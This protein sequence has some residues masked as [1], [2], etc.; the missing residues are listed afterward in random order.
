[1]PNPVDDPKKTASAGGNTPAAAIDPQTIRDEERKRV[2]RIQNLGSSLGATPQAIE[3][4]INDGLSFEAAFDALKESAKA[5]APSVPVPPRRIDVA[6]DEADKRHK[7]TVTALMLA[8]GINVPDAD[9]NVLTNGDVPKSLSGLQRAALRQSGNYSEARID[10]MSRNE[11]ARAVLREAR[12]SASGT[13]GSFTN[14]LEDT[15]NKS[16]GVGFD[17]GTGTWRPWVK[18]RPVN[19]YRE[20]SVVKMSTFADM[21]KIE[22]GMP[23]RHGAFDDKKESGSIDDYGKM[24]TVSNQTLVNDDLGA[25][26]EIPRKMGLS[27]DWY[28]NKLVY[29]T[30]YGAAGVGPTMAEDSKALFDA[31]NHGNYI[32][33]GAAPSVTTIAVGRKALMNMGGLIGSPE[34]TAHRLNLTPRWLIVPSSLETTAEQVIATN[35]DI[36]QSIAGVYNPFAANGRTPL[37]I[38]VDAYLDSKSTTGWYL[39]TDYNRMETIV[40]LALDGR[41]AP[42]VRTDESRVGEALGV[43]FDIHG[44]VGTMAADWRGLFLNDGVAE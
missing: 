40:M 2:T 28:L 5:Q 6:H 1:M 42:I 30:L 18:V 24:Y 26:T 16:V 36:G 15:I 3:S 39:A 9:R 14:I 20:Y 17:E 34:Q 44:S 11:L 21:E 22:Q 32:T 33:D 8:G 37:S 38:V 27:W 7:A 25:L 10:N 19:D 13:P 31:T 4:A 29:D 23:F 35:F 41:V 12:N 43:S